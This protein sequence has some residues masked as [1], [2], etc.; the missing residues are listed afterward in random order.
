MREQALR[1]IAMTY[2]R[3][4]VPKTCIDATEIK[5][6]E[7]TFVSLPYD[8]SSYT[9]YYEGEMGE[10]LKKIM[11][12][13]RGSFKQTDLYNFKKEAIKLEERF[14]VEGARRLNID[15]GYLSPSKLVLAT[16]KEYPGAIAIG[17]DLN[18]IVELVFHKGSYE[19]LIWTYRDYI[20][21]IN[22]FNLARKNIS[23][24]I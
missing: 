21:N 10:G 17:E 23:L 11:M 19:P 24:W 7:V 15:P 5:F 4:I 3:D 2:S 9:D 14:K 8:F 6:G 12:I 20:D 18:A 22:F 1:F 16:H 13:I